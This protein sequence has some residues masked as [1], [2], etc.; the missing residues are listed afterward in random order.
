MTTKPSPLNGTKGRK[1][2]PRMTPEEAARIVRGETLRSLREKSGYSI[3]EFARECEC[4]PSHIS[5]IEA[6]RR[7]AKPDLVVRMAHVLNVPVPVIEVRIVRD[8]TAA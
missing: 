5:N 8:G 1:Q 2:T 3:A 4:V 6:G 7:G